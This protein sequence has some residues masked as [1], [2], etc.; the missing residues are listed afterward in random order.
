MAPELGEVARTDDNR[1]VFQRENEYRQRQKKQQ[2]TCRFVHNRMNSH[3]PPLYG[4]SGN[5]IHNLYKG[6]DSDPYI[7]PCRNTQDRK[8]FDQA[9]DHKHK[10]R[11]RIQPCSKLA[12]GICFS[13]HKSIKHIRQP[14]RYVKHIKGR[15]EHRTEKQNDTGS[16]SEECYYVC[17]QC[18][19]L[20]S[21][22][23]ACFIS[24]R[25]WASASRSSRLICLRSVFISSRCL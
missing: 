5:D 12:D 18:P 2:N 14:G 23:F 10:V 6:N 7:Q 1:R 19:R 21:F 24:N 9:Y 11:N 16:Y 17:Y 13:R 25:R 3:K 22:F 4:K 20:F 8:Q 15:G